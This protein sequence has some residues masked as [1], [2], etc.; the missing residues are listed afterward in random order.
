[1]RLYQQSRNTGLCRTPSKILTQR[2]SL[3][4][5]FNARK[6]HQT[7]NSMSN[8]FVCHPTRISLLQPF[9]ETGKSAR[10]EANGRPVVGGRP[11][12]SR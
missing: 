5:K 2:E 1:M 10:R 4:S 8:L 7:E 9:K 3:T 6:A 11:Q 12:A